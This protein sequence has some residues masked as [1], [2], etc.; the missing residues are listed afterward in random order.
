[1][2]TVLGFVLGTVVYMVLLYF[3]DGRLKT[4]W[5]LL[6]AILISFVLLILSMFILSRL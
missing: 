1:M 3:F 4:G 6:L 5:I 2:S